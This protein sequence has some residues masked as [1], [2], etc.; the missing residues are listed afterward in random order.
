MNHTYTSQNLSFTA[1]LGN[2]L[3]IVM[4][5]SSLFN[6]ET[7]KNFNKKKYFSIFWPCFWL[8]HAR[9]LYKM[10]IIFT[11]FFPFEN[12][13]LLKYRAVYG[14]EIVQINRMPPAK[15]KLFF[16][17]LRTH[18]L[19]QQSTAK[20]VHAWFHSSLC[21]FVFC[22]SCS[23]RCVSL[24]EHES[25]CLVYD[26]VVLHAPA[27]KAATANRKKCEKEILMKFMRLRNCNQL[28]CNDITI[29]H[30]SHGS[31]DI[32]ACKFGHINVARESTACLCACSLACCR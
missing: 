10:L 26:L 16:S 4:L 14:N 24:H 19:T 21:R 31:N 13:Y 18:S 17:S 9:T 2:L 11:Y 20:R 12:M 30:A 23:I 6:L 22:C 5:F 32:A 1:L 3:R 7:S 28:L 29:A 25:I 27:C 15:I 8:C